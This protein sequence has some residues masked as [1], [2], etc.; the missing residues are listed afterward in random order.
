[1]P[2]RKKDTQHAIFERRLLG[3]QPDRRRKLTISSR[4]PVV[5]TEMIS[6]SVL[7]RSV[8]P[9]M[10][11]GEFVVDDR[12]RKSTRRATAPAVDS[13][14]AGRTVNNRDAGHQN[15]ISKSRTP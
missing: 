3:V 15:R 11:V 1:M 10:N 4:H 12:F 8:V 2:S 14:E 5:G 13:Q 6:E 7:M 9:K